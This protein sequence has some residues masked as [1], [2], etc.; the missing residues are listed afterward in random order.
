MTLQN[1]IEF[2]NAS[3]APAVLLTG[4]GLLLAGLQMKYSTIVGVIRQ[5]NGERRQMSEPSPS[6]TRVRQQIDSLM[7]RARLIRNAIFCFY[8]AVFFVVCSSIALGLGTLEIVTS[9]A[10]VFTLF[11]VALLM[12][13]IGLWNATREALLSYRIVQLESCDD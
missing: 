5:L 11:G 7:A 1:A 12:L 8:L 6:L 10:L 3:L 4:V 2:I 9:S 13:F